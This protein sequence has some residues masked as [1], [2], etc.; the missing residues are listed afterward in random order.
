LQVYQD[1]LI[2]FIVMN[3]YLSL[4]EA[5]HDRFHRDKGDSQILKLQKFFNLRGEILVTFVNGT[6]VHTGQH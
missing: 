6:F 4:D 3:P 1:S 5:W 2:I